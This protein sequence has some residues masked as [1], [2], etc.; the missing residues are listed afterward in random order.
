[1]KHTSSRLPSSMRYIVRILVTWPPTLLY[2]I[3][4][5]WLLTLRYFEAPLQSDVRISD[6]SL[7]PRYL[8]STV[9]FSSIAFVFVCSDEIRTMRLGLESM[10]IWRGSTARALYR[11]TRRQWLCQRC[12]LEAYSRSSRHC[13]DRSLEWN[14]A[15]GWLIRR[16]F[17]RS[18]EG[19]RRMFT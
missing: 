17:Q 7:K 9:S 12:P 6:S 1:M 4:P 3:I 10:G 5:T 18:Q 14:A 16:R 13:S 8:Y 19:E 2:N 11:S 15:L